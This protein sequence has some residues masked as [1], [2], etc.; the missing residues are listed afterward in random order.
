MNTNTVKISIYTEDKGDKYLP[1][2]RQVV[3]RYANGYTILRA[4][5][6][7]MGTPERSLKIE[8]IT[9]GDWVE[10]AEG[11]SQALRAVLCQEAVLFTAELVHMCSV[12]RN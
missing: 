12:E 3:G 5:G 9:D 4:E 8:I 2:V 11:C 7:W 6:V 1:L 10:I